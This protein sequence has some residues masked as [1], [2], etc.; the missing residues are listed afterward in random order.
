M[1]AGSN[2]AEVRKDQTAEAVARRCPLV[3]PTRE[4]DQSRH[5]TPG[6][7]CCPVTGAIMHVPGHLSLIVRFRTVIATQN[8][9]FPRPKFHRGGNPIQ[10][11][12]NFRLKGWEYSHQS[13][14]RRAPSRS[15]VRGNVWWR[16]EVLAEIARVLFPWKP[17]S[18]AGLCQCGMAGPL[19]CAP[20][21][22]RPAP[23]SLHH[24]TI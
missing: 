22:R 6:R 17:G 9:P 5:P 14:H 13:H 20:A 11:K 4:S 1:Q 10:T 19:P 2:A 8:G 12:P 24:I 21:P 3:P 18:R 7:S 16:L 15:F 23:K